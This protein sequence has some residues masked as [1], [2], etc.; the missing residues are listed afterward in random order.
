MNRGG[1]LLCLGGNGNL[2]VGTFFEPYL[3]AIFV[4]Q[5]ILNT[6]VSIAGPFHNNLRLFRLVRI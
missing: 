4:N 5:R 3:I 6:E 1:L 2:N